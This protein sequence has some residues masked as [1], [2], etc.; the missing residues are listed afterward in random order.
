MDVYENI[1]NRAYGQ[2]FGYG[3]D[4]CPPRVRSAREA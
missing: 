2:D 3:P 4:L 1:L